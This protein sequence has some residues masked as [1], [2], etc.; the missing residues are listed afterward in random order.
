MERRKGIASEAHVPHQ[1]SRYSYSPNS[2]HLLSAKRVGFGQFIL[3]ELTLFAERRHGGQP[4]G[5]SLS[6]LSAFLVQ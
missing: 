4:L 3:K 2:E 5:T 6:N 1:A